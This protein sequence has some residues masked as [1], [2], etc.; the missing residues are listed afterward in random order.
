MGR[1]VENPDSMGGG[2]DEIPAPEANTDE[3]PEDVSAFLRS[4]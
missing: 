1:Y 4:Q 3:Q 2:M